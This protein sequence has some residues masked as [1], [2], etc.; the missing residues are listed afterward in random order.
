VRLGPQGEQRRHDRPRSCRYPQTTTTSTG[1]LLML[2]LLLLCVAFDS[3]QTATTGNTLTKRKQQHNV[4]DSFPAHE[5]DEGEPAEKQQMFYMFLVLV[6]RS[7]LFVC[8]FL[9]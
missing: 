7:P 6:F 2:L 3:Q 4:D 9:K 1:H 5:G 8:Y